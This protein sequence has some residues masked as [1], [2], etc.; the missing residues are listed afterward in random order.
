[1]DLV[2]II[3]HRAKQA[4]ISY[5]IYLYGMYDLG[6]N[7]IF[8]LYYIIIFSTQVTWLSKQLEILAHIR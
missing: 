6:T 7:L 1:M 3:E 5:L 2:T 8:L 4:I